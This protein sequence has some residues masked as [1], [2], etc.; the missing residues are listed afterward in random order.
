VPKTGDNEAD[1]SDIH[2]S[3]ATKYD[4]LSARRKLKGIT[5]DIA[6]S[7]YDEEP[8]MKAT[9]VAGFAQTRVASLR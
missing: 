6:W 3:A 1:D 7:I 4:R 9:P 2:E 8:S 5:R